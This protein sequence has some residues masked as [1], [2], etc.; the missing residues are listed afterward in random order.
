MKLEVRLIDDWHRAWRKAS[1]IIS[2]AFVLLYG[3]M[4]EL[5]PPLADHWPEIYPYAL[6]FFPHADQALGPCIGGVLTIVARLVSIRVKHADQ[7]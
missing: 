5:L 2:A 7:P 6:K 3:F 1:V 4:A